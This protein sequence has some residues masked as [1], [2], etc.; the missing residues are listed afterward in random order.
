MTRDR[1]PPDRRRTSPRSAWPAVT[2]MILAADGS[3]TLLLEALLDVELSV[4]V[5]GQRIVTADSVAPRTRRLLQVA[6]GT[7]VLVRRSLLCRPGGQ[8]VSQNYVAAPYRRDGL[9][10]VLADPT[11]PI[12]RGLSSLGLSQ[13]RRIVEVGLSAWSPTSTCVSKSYLIMNQ[14]GVG[15][16]VVERFHPGVV[17]VCGEAAGGADGSRDEQRDP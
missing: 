12:G 13:A 4:R 1:R 3:T 10:R 15:A 5:L 17:P 7:D 16:Y 8:Y 9:T 14:G 11:Q 2:R 6:P